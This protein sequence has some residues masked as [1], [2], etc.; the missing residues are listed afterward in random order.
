MK[1]SCK[2]F[3]DQDGRYVLGP[4][5]M[6]LLRSIEELGS[7]RKAAHKLGMS[8]R[9]AWGRLNDM[10]HALG[11]ELLSHGGGAAKSLT[12]HAHE[13]LA[14]YNKTERALA[15]QLEQAARECPA[16][17]D[18]A[19]ATPDATNAANVTGTTER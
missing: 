15:A 18:A 10:E 4:G 2:F 6:E 3:L 7:L 17:I 13:L 5:R 19:K 8:Y 16:F 9:W 1:L 11:V 12:R 14:W